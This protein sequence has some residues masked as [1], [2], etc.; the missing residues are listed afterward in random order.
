MLAEQQ[1]QRQKLPH[2]SSVVEDGFRI[3]EQTFMGQQQQLT[4]GALPFTE[5]RDDR[6]LL[7]PASKLPG[8][9][10]DV[11]SRLEDQTIYPHPTVIPPARRK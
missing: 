1:L 2:V 7:R 4:Q 3:T 5:A 11:D 8:T 6:R 10:P 9:P